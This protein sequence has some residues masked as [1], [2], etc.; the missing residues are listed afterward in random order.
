MEIS[1][2]HHLSSI[3][4]NIPSLA[5]SSEAT[6]IS[7]SSR[8]EQAIVAIKKLQEYPGKFKEFVIAK[9]KRGLHTN[10]GEAVKLHQ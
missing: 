9:L 6:Q 2:D 3:S 1:M 5:D 10:N 4:S 7:K 8:L